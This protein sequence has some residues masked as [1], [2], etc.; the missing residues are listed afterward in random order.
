MAYYGFPVRG[1]YSLKDLPL[2]CI[3]FGCCQHYLAY[4]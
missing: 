2:R 4:I 1:M 3:D